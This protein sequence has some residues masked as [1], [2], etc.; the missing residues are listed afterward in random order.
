VERK[1]EKRREKERKGEKRRDIT[2][3]SILS[4]YLGWKT[5]CQ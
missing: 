2:V 5:I 3:G 4:V 1:G